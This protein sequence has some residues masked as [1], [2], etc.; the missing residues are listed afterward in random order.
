MREDRVDFSIIIRMAISLFPIF[1]GLPTVAVVMCAYNLAMSIILLGP[2]TSIVSSLTAALIS[3][4]FYGFIVQGGELLGLFVALEAILM[5]AICGVVFLKRQSF[6]KGVWLS[7]A[8]YLT[9]SYINMMQSAHKMGQSV[10]DYLT[11]ASFEQIKVQFMQ[12][13]GQ[14]Q[15]GEEEI[16][17][18]FD[19]IRKIIVMVIPSTLVLMSIIIGYIVMW[20]VNYFLRKIPA[21]KKDAH[22]FALLR[23]P[24]MAVLFMIFVTV[25]CF[26]FKSDDIFYVLINVVVVFGGLCFFSGMS[27]VDFFLRRKIEKMLP[28]IGVHFLIYMLSGFITGIIPY[29]NIIF[30]YI[31]I[32][33]LDSFVNIRRIKPIKEE[34]EVNEEE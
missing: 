34:G 12:T 31:V 23:M 21:F 8:G 29:A 6:Y 20:C 15:L 32:A 26:V 1:L 22:S 11:L 17:A 5:G 13:I 16:V 10:A 19:A 24:K 3:M 14:I 7:G 28:R 30:V 9:V 18:I 25:L 4:L 2:V 27:V 33:M